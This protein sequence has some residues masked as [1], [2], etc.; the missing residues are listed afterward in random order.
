MADGRRADG[1]RRRQRVKSAIVQATRT[2]TTISVSGIAR[3]AGVDRTFLLRCRDTSQR[4]NE[5]IL[6]LR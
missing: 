2:G 3:Q 4:G 5:L 1:E 6:K